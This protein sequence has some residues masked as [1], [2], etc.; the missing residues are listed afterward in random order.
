ME[1]LKFKSI[2]EILQYA[3]NEESEAGIFYG[4][5]AKQTTNLE[6]KKVW[7]QLSHDELR[8]KAIL[9]ALLEKMENGE[10]LITYSNEDVKDYIP[11]NPKV[12][13]YNE[14]EMAIITAIQN[15][16]NAYFMYKHLSEKVANTNHSNI[17]LTL[18]NEE[19]K[20]KQSLMYELGS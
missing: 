19:L 5:Q 3:I 12:K 18:A 9:S 14:M 7:E 15:E 16:N 20:H 1:E 4:E 10:E 6:L 8:H 11:F 17:L 13:E 2:E